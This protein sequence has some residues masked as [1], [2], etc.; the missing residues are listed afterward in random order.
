MPHKL[1]DLKTVTD[2][3]ISL[4]RREWGELFG[5]PRGRVVITDDLPDGP[6]TITN[7]TVEKE[8]LE[9]DNNN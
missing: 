2:D 3:T 9:N 8:R 7:D 6:F 4:Y 5:I 1:Q